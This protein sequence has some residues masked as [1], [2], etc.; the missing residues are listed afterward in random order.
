MPIMLVMPNGEAA[1]ATVHRAAVF[2]EK[3][4]YC[5]GHRSISTLP[6]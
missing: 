6:A 5:G 1:A 2:D 3:P 4:H